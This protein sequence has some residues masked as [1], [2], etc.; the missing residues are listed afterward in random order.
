MR[1]NVITNHALRACLLLGVTT[2][3]MGCRSQ[4][5]LNKCGSNDPDSKIAGCTALIQAGKGT[6]E[7]ISTFYNN[8]A[9]AYDDKHDYA[10]AI[11]DYD[12]AIRLN[13]N[14]SFAFYGRGEA[15]D[16][17]NEF[18]RAIQDYDQA[19]RLNPNFSYA[20]DARG[21]AHRNKG[22]FDQAIR[23][24]DEAIRLDPNYAL[25]FNNRGDSYRSKGDYDHAIQ[26]F[27]EAIRLNPKLISAYGNRGFVYLSQS[28]LPAATTDYEHVIVAAPSSTT[29]VV[30]ALELH[31][32]M[33]RQG[34]DDSKLLAKVAAAADLSKW[35]GPILKLDLGQMTADELM[36]TAAHAGA[37]NQKW[38][39]CEANFFT[40]EDALL[41][42]QRAKAIARLK[43]ARDGC[44][45][46]QGSYGQAVAELK[47]LGVSS[48]P[49]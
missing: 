28:N 11:Q 13:P 2:T 26:D 29:A 5:N 38:E 40:G 49:N 33:K 37:E 4:E 48:L 21:R 24:Y 47:W 35:P 12:E 46:A 8:R 15:Y 19:I 42:H 10:H 9:V 17:T 41:N 32:A 7:S 23:D 45:K 3:A 44:P 6:P 25:A 20:Y 1:L 43:A 30:G 39:I 16:H 36:A 18:D 22:E 31:L 34:L 14:L 27:N